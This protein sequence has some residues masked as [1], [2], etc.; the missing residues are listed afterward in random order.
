MSDSRNLSSTTLFWQRLVSW[1]VWGL[2]ALLLVWIVI[3]VTVGVF[4]G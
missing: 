2:F 4:E 1:T 3:S